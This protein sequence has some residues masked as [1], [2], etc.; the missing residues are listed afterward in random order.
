MREGIIAI[1]AEGRITTFNRAAIDT[2]GLG[3]EPLTGR[4]IQEVLPE[5]RLPALLES[6]EPEFDTEVVIGGRS[7][8]INRIPIRVKGQLTGVVSSFR[9]RD[10]LAMVSRQLTR[11][12]QY[13]ETLRSQAHEYANKL[14]T[15]AGLIQLDKSREALELIGQETQDHQTMLRW[16]VDSVADP[17]VS[18]CLLGKFNRAHELGLQLVIDPESHLDALP[19]HI[20]PEQLVT[21]IGN[22]LDNAFDAT[23]GAQGTQINLS[24]TD[25]GQDLIIEVEDKGPGVPDTD[26]D[27]VFERGFSRKS[28]G[29]GIGLHLVKE[30]VTQLSGEIVVENLPGGGAR[31][32]LYLPKEIRK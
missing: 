25:I 19:S 13:A 15:I 31:F 2:L 22:L 29:R 30:I 3:S 6:G 20:T 14:H 10:E 23:L 28:E 16:L 1:N 5:S 12:Q 8:I 17:V 26:L 7:L 21:L 32:T 18:G 4:L 11:I 9:V 24:L 27:Q